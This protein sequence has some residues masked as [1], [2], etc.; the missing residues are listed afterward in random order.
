MLQREYELWDHEQL[1]TLRR[2]QVK[3]LC[4][5]RQVDHFETLISSFA[6]GGSVATGRIAEKVKRLKDIARE[7]EEKANVLSPF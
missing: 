3:G 6:V 2:H 5:E 4:S 7:L 1:L